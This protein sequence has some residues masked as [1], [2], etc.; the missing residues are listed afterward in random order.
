VRSLGSASRNRNV[1]TKFTILACALALSAGGCGGA[2]VG[3]QK[4][5]N[6][7]LESEERTLDCQRLHNSIWGR[8]QV[9]KALPEK[10]RNERAREPPTAALA[11]GRIFG[12]KSKGLQTLEEYD[13]EHAHVR[14]L[15]RA[16]L[17]RGC[18]P[19]DVERELAST[20]AV[21]AEFRKE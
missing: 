11:I 18:P 4:D 20:D 10:I 16:A 19:I 14:A 5:G 15:H 21:I 13:R 17:D 1:R 6:Y 7:L 2:S 12:S 3:L 8:L 9:M